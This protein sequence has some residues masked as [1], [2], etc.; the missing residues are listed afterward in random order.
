LS[1]RIPVG[2]SSAVGLRAHLEGKHRGCPAD[3][4][5]RCDYHGRDDDPADFILGCPARY[6]EPGLREVVFECIR[7][8]DMG[9]LGEVTGRPIAAL[10]SRLVDLYTEA[11]A[12]RDRFTA[13]RQR[14]EAKAREK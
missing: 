4:K 5:V 2:K 10:P 1:Q 7:W 12:A 8:E 13:W 11:L 3:A 9:G 6:L 14:A